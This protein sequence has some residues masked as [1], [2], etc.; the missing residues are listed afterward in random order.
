MAPTTSPRPSP[1][2]GQEEDALLYAGSLA[3][4]AVGYVNCRGDVYDRHD[5]KVGH[6]MVAWN[7]DG[8]IFRGYDV[9]AGH[10]TVASNGDGLISV[11]Q[12]RTVRGVATARGDIYAGCYEHKVAVVKPRVDVTRMGAVALLLGVLSPAEET[13]RT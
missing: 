13:P 8:V 9:E 7:G 3:V 10:V 12:D 1:Y 4:D 2:R 11:G 5:Y 6:V